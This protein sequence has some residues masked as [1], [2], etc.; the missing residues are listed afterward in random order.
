VSGAAAPVVVEARGLAKRWGAVVAL[1]GADLTVRRGEVVC[2]VGPSGSGK[3]TLLRCLNGLEV[4]DAGTVTVAG[5]SVRA[6]TPGIDA[7]RARIGMVFQAFHLFPHLTAAENLA[8]APRLVRGARRDDAMDR[9]CALLGRVGLADRADARPDQLSGGQKQRVAIARALAMDPEVLLCDEPTSALDPETV[10]EVLAV[11]RDLALGGM[12]MV[13]VTH[14]MGFARD[15][16][17]RTVFMDAGR[18]VE[19]GPSADLL[20]A[21]R[22]PRLRDFL[23]RVLRPLDGGLAP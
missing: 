2:V 13:V 19:E 21:P 17:T 5:V 6:G 11:L 4:P 10:G 22:S 9:A 14:E 23:A 16:S 12:T 15:V 18:V 7:A 1:D 8:L 20:R 3:S